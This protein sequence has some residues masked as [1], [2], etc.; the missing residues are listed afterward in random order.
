MKK[1]T[2]ITTDVSYWV[3]M[4]HN[5]WKIQPSIGFSNGLNGV[6]CSHEKSRKITGMRLPAIFST[7]MSNHHVAG[8]MF[9]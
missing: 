8:V 4:T 7:A 2:K 6:Y 9:S 5:Q 1:M 3:F